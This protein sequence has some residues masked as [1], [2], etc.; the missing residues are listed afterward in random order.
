MDRL[1]AM[2]VFVRVAETGGF[3]DAARRLGLSPPAATRAVAGLEA[4]IGARLLTR[5]TRSVKL[6]EAGARYLEDCRRL[7]AELAEAE[8]AAAGSY[9]TPTGTLTVT[10]S[11]LFGQIYVL[12]VVLEFLGLHPAVSVRTLFV[13]RVTSLVEEG[14]DAAVRIGHLADSGLAATRVGSVRRVV[15]AAPAYLERHGI[16]RTPAELAEHGVVATTHSW[17]ALEW[18]FGG[19]RRTAVTVRPRLVCNTNEAA[20]SA[21]E[22]GWGLVRALSY[23]VAP[24]LAA[25]RLQAVL[26]AYE[27]APLPI[28]VVHPEG[29]H[30]AAK[31]RAFVDLAVERLRGNPLIA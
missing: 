7:L 20:I 26:S 19:A 13:D 4:A 12:P 25:G 18:R 28:H 3:A 1:Q 8:A 29:R 22:A 11:L 24:A 2:R 23:Q 15:C 14:I 16:P 9:A 31:V 5:T 27:E 10:A 17:G 6:T 21:A 30:A